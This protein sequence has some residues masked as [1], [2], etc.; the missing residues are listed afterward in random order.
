MMVSGENS[1]LTSVES[2]VADLRD[3]IVRQV[4]GPGTRLKERELAEEMAVS[5]AVIRDAFSVLA[6]RKLIVRHANRG[7]EVAALGVDDINE[8][9]EAR[10]AIEGLIARLAAERA[11]DGAWDVLKTSFGEPVGDAIA[12]GQ[13]DVYWR[14]I[15]EMQAA[16]I[17]HAGNSVLTE[18]TSLLADRSAV[19]ARRS[20]FLPGRAQ[21]GLRLHREVIWALADRRGEDAERLKRQ[22]LRDARNRLL[23]YANYVY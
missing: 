15:D 13:L 1:E 11:P 18:L 4:Y 14:F 3:R 7:A 20:V 19:L 9:Y 6:E 23:K 21:E 22:N 8:V 12:S 5:R 2:V 16:M 17:L 10:E